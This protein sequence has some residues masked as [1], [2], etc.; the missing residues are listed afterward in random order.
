MR[1]I[2]TL[3]LA[4]VIGTT[5]ACTAKLGT[6][7][8]GKDG[9]AEF[10]YGSLDCLFGCSTRPM[11]HGTEETIFVTAKT[12]PLP[13]LDVRSSGPAVVVTSSDAVCC[14]QEL[15][16]TSCRIAAGLACAADEKGAVVVNVQGAAAGSSDIVLTQKDGSEWDRTTIEVA[17]PARLE[18]AC[19]GSR[20][21]AMT[22]GQTCNM[23][24]KAFDA[25]GRELQANTGVKLT[26]APREVAAFHHLIAADSWSEDGDQT[27]LGPWVISLAPGD[28]EITAAAGQTT[29]TMTLHVSAK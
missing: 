12:G 5:A 22:V 15:T 18:L 19:N 11:M 27:V 8:D 23:D 10:A 25:T 14:K 1:T 24:W 6:A 17:D 3:S 20:D 4:L 26:L 16:S 13:A 9:R 29:S 28:A 7:T 21:G 2:G